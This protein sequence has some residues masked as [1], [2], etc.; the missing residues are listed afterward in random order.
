MPKKKSPT[1]GAILGFIFGP[2]GYIY[3][4]WKYA[5][6]GVAVYTVFFLILMPLDLDPAILRT[7]PGGRF[8]V[9]LPLAIVFAWKAYTICSLRNALIEAEDERATMLNTFSVAGMAMTDLLV[10]IAII[11]AG[12]LGIYLSVITFLGGNLVKSLVYLAIGTPVLVW[13]A[14]IVFGFIAAGIDIL[15]A[16]GAENFFR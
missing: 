5:L 6:M 10:G 4:G 16:K 1:A 14:S 7:L 2:F 13:I 12:A 11:Y 3:I 8:M 15:F 9:H